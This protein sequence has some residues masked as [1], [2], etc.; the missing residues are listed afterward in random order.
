VVVSALVG[1]QTNVV[2]NSDQQG[3]KSDQ[4]G[5][6]SDQQ[7]RKLFGSKSEIISDQHLQKRVGRK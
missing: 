5:R 7:G 6:K 2:G 4:R 1:N 3:R